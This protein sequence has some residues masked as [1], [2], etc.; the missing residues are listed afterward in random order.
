M[1]TI[2]IESTLGSSKYNIYLGELSSLQFLGKVIIVTNAKIHNLHIKYLLNKIQ[3]KDVFIC[4]IDD[5]EQYKN[6]QT[7]QNILDFAFSHNLSREDSIIAFGGGVIGDI[8]AFVAGIYKRGISFINIPTTLLSQVDASVGGKCGVNNAFGKNLIGLFNNPKSV[9]IDTSFLKTLPSREFKA[10]LSEIIK[11]AICFDR[12]FFI[13]L[14]N[15]NLE[16]E[17]Q[18]IYAINKSI[19]IKAKVVSL[20]WKEKSVRAKLNYAHTFG[21]V[22]ELLGNYEK[23]LHGESISIGMRMANELAVKLGLLKL[24]DAKLIKSVLDRFELT[25]KYKVEDVNKFYEYLFLDKK[26]K[27]NKIN[28]ILPTAIG[29]VEMVSNVPENIIFDVLNLE[30]D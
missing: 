4:L 26:N 29:F 20:D 7:V 13:W 18:L 14:V 1:D 17:K 9:H 21:H 30:Y 5:G 22:I 28:F 3:C 27:E 24:E 11:I 12:D 23:Y 15:A 16:D 8:T 25:T 19:N 10:G 6:M 2:S